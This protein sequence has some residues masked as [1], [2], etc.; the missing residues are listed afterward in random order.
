MSTHEQIAPL[1]DAYPAALKN[2]K[3]PIYANISH[4]YGGDETPTPQ[5]AINSATGCEAS[6]S[7]GATATTA[8]AT[9]AAAAAVSA[10]AVAVA[11]AVIIAVA[12]VIVAIHRTAH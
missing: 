4:Y 11:V 6:T 5:V 10:V 2:V 12:E 7:V 9:T 1:L 8:T 3:L